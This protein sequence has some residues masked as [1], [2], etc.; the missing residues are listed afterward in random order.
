MMNAAYAFTQQLRPQDYVALVTFDMHTQIITDFTQDK[1]ADPAGSQMLQVPGFSETNVFDALY[2][3]LDRLDRIDG[4][5][6]IVL[7]GTGRDTFSKLTFDKIMARVKASHN[8]TIFTISTGGMI[9]AMTEG[10]GG[11]ES[12]IRDMDNL[13]ADNE[14]RTFSSLTGGMSFFPRFEG[15]LPDIFHEH[16]PEHPLEIR[17][18]LLVPPTPSRTAPI[19][20]CAWRWSTTRASRCASRI[21]STSPSS[22][23]SL[24]A[25]AT[26]PSR[27]WSK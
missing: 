16:Q 13:Q 12:S 8:V 24:L 2:E 22:T 10:R 3:S 14:M 6:Y 27:K 26:A 11:M 19:A 25:T 15:E 20:S 23:T 18:G 7:I 5:K 21:R 17:T 9:R 4:Q 1:T